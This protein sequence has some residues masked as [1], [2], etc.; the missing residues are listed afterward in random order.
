MFNIAPNRHVL[1][2][3]L[4]VEGASGS[5]N[6]VPH[7]G[8]QRMSVN[9]TAQLVAPRG[10]PARVEVSDAEL[11]QRVDHGELS[12]LGALYDR[13]HDSVRQFLARATAQGSDADDLTH[14]TFLALAKIAGR[15]DGRASARPFLIGIAAQLVRR[16]RRGFAR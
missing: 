6:D 3:I 7:E 14:E 10:A 8:F 4:L 16:R 9:R 13:H 2:V 12:A 5:Y 11:L 15:Y 1:A